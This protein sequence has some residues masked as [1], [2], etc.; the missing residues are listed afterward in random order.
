MSIK[1]KI[2]LALAGAFIG[3]INGFFGGGGGMIAVPSL[4]LILKQEQKISHA[5]ALAVILPLTL[6]S[7]IAYLASGKASFELGN[8]LA[9][10]ISV[11]VGGVLGAMLL[12]KANNKILSKIF[13]VLMLVAGVKMAVW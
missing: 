2:L 13:A 1:N 7:A 3:F 5:T 11:T 10:T 12:K 6:V 9:T 8:T 4:T